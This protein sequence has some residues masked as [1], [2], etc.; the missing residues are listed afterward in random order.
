M[1]GRLQVVF[2][3]FLILS[4]CGYD[5]EEELFG[6]KLC[7]PEQVTYSGVIAPLITTNCAIT[8]CHDGN[9]PNLPN[10]SIFEN[11]KANA[12]EIRER[13]TDGT[14]PPSASGLILS[15]EGIDNIACWVEN[16]AQNN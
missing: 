6:S 10:W 4:A 15:A 1:K 14:M 5:N 8:S 3:G 11:V 13:T 9:N 2:M 12:Q 16:G 7:D